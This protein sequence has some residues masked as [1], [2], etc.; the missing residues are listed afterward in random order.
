MPSRPTIVRWMGFAT[1]WFLFTCVSTVQAAWTQEIYVWQRQNGPD[2]TASLENF[3]TFADG[4]PILAAEVAW[5]SGGPPK[6]IRPPRDYAQLARL[7]RP[8]GLVLR[9]GSYAGSFSTDASATK[10]LTAL[11]RSLL[12]EARAGGLTA[13]ELQVDFD[14]AES[15][16]DG[17]RLWLEALHRAAEGTPIVFTALPAWLRHTEDFSRLAHAADGFV[18]QVHSL[19]KPT[20]PDTPFTLCDPARALAWA[21]QASRVGAPFRIA[22]PTYGYLVA[23]DKTGKFIALAAEGPRVGWPAGTQVR[24][25]RADAVAMANLSRSLAARRPSH[26]TG[27]IWFRLPVTGDRLNWDA[28]TLA[29][30]MRGEIPSAKIAAEVTWPETGLAEISVVNTGATTEPLP[31]HVDLT[32][33]KAVT[34]IA[35]DGLGGF[36]L[37]THGTEGHG[38]VVNAGASPDAFL[39]PGRRVKIAWL[40]FPHELSLDACFPPKP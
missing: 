20:S 11:V 6:I 16:L 21:E 27:I 17:Y 32:W 40:R 2:V 15:K 36:R 14:C 10:T 8:F 39:A 5:T 22:L 33:P 29:T 25:V 18:L 1:G 3:R 34:P 9:V 35:F 28:L 23:F 24:T 26:C 31:D 4:F 37:D 19:E 38:I 30:V 7:Q 12:A 13:S